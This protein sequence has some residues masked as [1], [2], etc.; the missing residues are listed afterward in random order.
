MLLLRLGNEGIAGK[1]G[2]ELWDMVW[3]WRGGGAFWFTPCREYGLKYGVF[4]EGL[5][6]QREWHAKNM[7]KGSIGWSSGIYFTKLT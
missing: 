7:F 6:K 3:N 1:G 2:E 5:L 4:E